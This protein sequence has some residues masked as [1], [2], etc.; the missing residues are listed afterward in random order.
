[1]HTCITNYIKKYWK[2]FYQQ[3]Y[4]HTAHLTTGVSPAAKM[5]ED[6]KQTHFPKKRIS[7]EECIKARS[8]KNG[9]KPETAAQINCSK[10]RKKD[11]IKE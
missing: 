9:L 3:N 8:R 7:E 2:V 6:G 5:F 4:E 11:D 1:M 10:Y